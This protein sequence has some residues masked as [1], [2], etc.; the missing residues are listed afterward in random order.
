[1]DGELDGKLVKT[2]GTIEFLGPG[3]VGWIANTGGLRAKSFGAK[4]N[5]C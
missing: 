2:K 5:N 4:L 1:M 3:E